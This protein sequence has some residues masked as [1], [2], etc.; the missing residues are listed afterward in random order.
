MRVE[1]PSCIITYRL[2]VRFFT[3]QKYIHAN[4]SIKLPK[5]ALTACLLAKMDSNIVRKKER[6]KRNY[7]LKREVLNKFGNLHPK[8]QE[9]IP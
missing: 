8:H 2:G 7:S 1:T 6:K 4:Y 5:K 3:A 9:K